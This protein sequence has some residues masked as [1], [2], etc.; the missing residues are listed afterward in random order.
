VH[1]KNKLN[2]TD[3][4][5][6]RRIHVLGNS[7]SGKS[8]VGRQLAANL[9]IPFVELDALNWEPHWIGLNEYNPE[10]L[11]RKIKEATAGNE[12][13]VAGSYESF[14]KRV[15]W[16]RLQTIIWLDLPMY[17]LIV[18]MIKRS[19]TRWRSKKLLWGTNYEEF[20]PQLMFWRKEDSLLW[21]IVTQH[22]RKRLGMY[23]NISDP[24]WAHIDFIH[25]KSLKEID[26][27][28]ASLEY[29]KSV[30]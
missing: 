9:E 21:W 23:K 10:E 13:V 16:P 4:R 27:F 2:P 26:E 6:G 7:C 17:L 29:T 25:L 14:S 24:S 18:R 30:S 5:I 20:W 15:F 11:E 28:L 3:I 1:Q 8:S 19:W 12:W 22:E